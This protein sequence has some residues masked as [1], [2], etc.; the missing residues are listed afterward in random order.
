LTRY[1]IG[2]LEK[3]KIGTEVSFQTKRLRVRKSRPKIDEITGVHEQIE[4][5]KMR[6][7]ARSPW[8]G[9]CKRLKCGGNLN[10]HGRGGSEAE[11]RPYLPR[12]YQIR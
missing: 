2:W 6:N 7:D 8:A 5:D 11:K 9:Y 10:H 3:G 4:R 1:S 12:N